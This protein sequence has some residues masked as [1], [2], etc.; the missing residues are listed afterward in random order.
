MELIQMA[1]L[2][3]L[4]LTLLNQHDD[5]SNLDWKQIEKLMEIQ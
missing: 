2:H 5:I 3:Q 4:A 1:G